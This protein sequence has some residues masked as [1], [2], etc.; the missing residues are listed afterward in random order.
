MLYVSA[1][2]TRSLVDNES[3]VVNN[4]DKIQFG[5]NGFANS[6]KFLSL[7][8]RRLQTERKERVAFQL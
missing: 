3:S 7:T 1:T 5:L 6:F 2:T 4:L 8:Q